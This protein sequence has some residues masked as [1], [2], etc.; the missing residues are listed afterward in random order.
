[1]L[2]AMAAAVVYARAKRT[3]HKAFNEHVTKLV[4]PQPTDEGC[5]SVWE[6]AARGLAHPQLN[7]DNE[8]A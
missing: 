7:W 6:S 1:M 5:Q 2:T 4:I 8:W 3:A